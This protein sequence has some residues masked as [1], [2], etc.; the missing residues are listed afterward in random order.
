MLF[1]FLF[2]KGSGRSLERSPLL[3]ALLVRGS[4]PRWPHNG[5][6]IHGF[7]KRWFLAWW[8]VGQIKTMR[9]KRR[10]NKE[11]EIHDKFTADV[12][13][14]D[15]KHTE[16]HDG[17]CLLSNRWDL[18]HLSPSPNTSILF[19]ILTGCTYSVWVREL[20]GQLTCSYQRSEQEREGASWTWFC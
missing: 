17:L 4:W 19:S 13:V 6:T 20:R 7:K 14:T 16:G 15:R 10:K 11:R 18:G 5:V 3:P 2:G 12:S 9:F 8:L 1:L